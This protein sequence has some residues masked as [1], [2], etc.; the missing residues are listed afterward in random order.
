MLEIEGHKVTL[1]E[2]GEE[3]LHHLLESQ[4]DVAILDVNMP[5]LTGIEAA[6]SYMSGLGSDARIPMIGLTADISARTR[7][8]CLKAGMIDVLA[9]PVTLEQLH[10]AL[11][12]AGHRAPAPLG[13]HPAAD[14]E[15]ERDAPV[16]DQERLDFLHQLFGAAT[17]RNHFLA[18]FR[19]DVSHNLRLVAEGIEA[20]RAKPVRDALHAIKS[21]AGTA[22][23]RR[24]FLTAARLEKSDLGSASGLMEAELRREFD[25]YC[26]AAEGVEQET[27]PAAQAKLA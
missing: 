23:A 16:A 6:R 27:P 10:A 26:E 15:I 25:A 12:D 21:S 3:A 7:E 13:A 20:R 11:A 18:S 24:L 22:G 14:D 8:E 1:A 9:K 5:R 2:T 17:F 19:R 4:I